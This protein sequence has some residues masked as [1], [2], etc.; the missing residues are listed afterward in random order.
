M[1]GDTLYVLD[2]TALL[3]RHYFGKIKL[4][5][6]EGVEV[7]AVL[8]LCSSIARVFR[9]ARPPFAAVVFDAGRRT[10]R[11]DIDPAYKA[12]RGEPPEDLV[13]QFNL[14][15][16]ACRALGL[17]TYLL[18]GWEADDLMATLAAKA[19][20]WGLTT[21][22]VANDKDL[23]QCVRPM[24]RCLDL[25]K[26]VVLD[27]AAVHAKLGVRPDQV[28][29]YLALVGDSVDN[30]PGVR[31]VGAKTAAKLLARFD[32]IEGIYDDLEG[33]LYIGL[34][35]A[36][37]IQSRLASGREDV[38]RSR[39]LVTLVQDVPHPEIQALT[40]PEGLRWGGVPA[41]ADPIFDRM[42]F[43]GP[44]RSLRAL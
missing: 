44:L 19:E 37:G 21:V 22:L 4:T 35:G 6:A 32:S 1:S 28:I 43:H 25:R 39:Q 14:G 42:G 15:V 2:G 12:N 29:D 16:E 8:G 41:D 36:R 34:R 10:F 11:N 30:V 27:G 9:D 20:G 33:V 24:V 38:A 40:G 23:L 5:S 7:G 13:P 3:F 18:P 26:N 31:G 17:P